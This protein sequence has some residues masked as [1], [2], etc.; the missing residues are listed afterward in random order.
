LKKLHADRLRKEN[1][2]LGKKLEV[3]PRLKD[4]TL[5]FSIVVEKCS[6]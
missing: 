4:A 5:T 6:V 1:A 2:E 3:E